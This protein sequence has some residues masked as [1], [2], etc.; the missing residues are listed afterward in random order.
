VAALLL[1]QTWLFLQIYAQCL[2]VLGRAA[3][4]III[5]IVMHAICPGREGKGRD[6]SIPK[7][8]ACMHANV[9]QANS[10]TH[11]QTPDRDVLGTGSPEI[12][13][14]QTLT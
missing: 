13:G 4:S 11:H 2:G 3:V 5:R 14:R 8:H 12:K 10:P 7:P 6:K 9:Q 1:L